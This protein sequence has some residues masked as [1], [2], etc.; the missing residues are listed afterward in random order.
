MSQNVK[1]PSSIIDSLVKVLTT[2][3]ALFPAAL[4][5]IAAIVNIF[6]TGIK[7]GKSLA[8]IE[9]EAT[10]SM[11]TALRTRAKSEQQLG[12]QP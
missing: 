6:K 10:D 1:D 4:P 2:T 12:D 3:N 11:A 5:G 7:S 9:A 8:E